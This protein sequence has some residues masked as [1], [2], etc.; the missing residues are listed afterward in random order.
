MDEKTI[1]KLT[2]LADRIHEK[3]L[4]LL[5]NGEFDDI[6][7]S[8]E[9]NAKT[10]ADGNSLNLGINLILFDG[11]REKPMQLLD[12]ALTCNSG[13]TPFI[14]SGDMTLHKYIVNGTI[15]KVP[16]DYCPNCWGEWAF[17]LTNPTC[18]ECEYTMGKEIKLLLDT[19]ICP[20]CEEGKVS[21][22]QNKCDECGYTIAND[23]VEWG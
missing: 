15:Q 14:A 19:D 9:M 17:K 12:T 2:E 21:M 3:F 5:E 8:L 22:N 1:D 16:Q 6:A 13:D 23:M 11:N 20:H 4:E 10:L 18:S 7:E